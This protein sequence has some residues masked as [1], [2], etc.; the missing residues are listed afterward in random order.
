MLELL[1]LCNRNEN[2]IKV[3]YGRTGEK[4]ER[5]KRQTGGIISIGYY[6]GEE[7]K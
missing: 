1:A 3:L 6:G 2:D 5:R 4:R 7:V